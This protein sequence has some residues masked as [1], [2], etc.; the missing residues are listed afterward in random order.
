MP[1][2]DRKLIVLQLIQK[3]KSYNTL[4]LS[5]ITP[6]LNSNILVTISFLI[7]INYSKLPVGCMD[8]FVIFYIKRF[9]RMLYI[10]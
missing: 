8:Y 2:L 3:K 5:I 7:N 1:L 9:W 4:D 6:Q 10:L